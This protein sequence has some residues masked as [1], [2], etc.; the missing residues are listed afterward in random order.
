MMHVWMAPVSGGPLAPDPGPVA[1]VQAA[2]QLPPPAVAN[3][4][5]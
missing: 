5:A 1:E 4:V 2:A 3:G